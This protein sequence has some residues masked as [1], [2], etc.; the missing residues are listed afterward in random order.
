MPRI[1]ASAPWSMRP[2][3]DF[4][5]EE[6]DEVVWVGRLAVVIERAQPHHVVAQV[7]K[8]DAHA[9]TGR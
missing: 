7:Y 4:R 9:V 8:T 2:F 5:G 6:L 1:S 3:F